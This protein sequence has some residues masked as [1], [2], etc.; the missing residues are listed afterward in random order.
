MD[1][2][3]GS[4]ITGIVNNGTF[5]FATITVAQAAVQTS[6]AGSGGAGAGNRGLIHLDAGIYSQATNGET[7]PLLMS[8]WIDIQGVGAKQTV[9]RG[10]QDTPVNSFLPLSDNGTCGVRTNNMV[11]VDFSSATNAS[12]DE[13]IDG[14]SFQGSDIQVYAEAGT[15]PIHGRVSNCIFDLLD[16]PGEGY[17][18]PQFGVLMVHR[19]QAS[20]GDPTDPVGGKGEP[21][22]GGGSAGV[23]HDVKLNVFNNTFVQSWDPT[24]LPGE[25]EPE[26]SAL[27]ESVA[28][29]DVNDPG[30]GTA[31][32][33]PTPS[34]RGVGNPN[35]QNNLIRAFDATPPSALLGIDNADVTCAVGTR[36]GATNG[37]DPL[38]VG[39]TGAAPVTP[40]MFYSSNVIGST[41]VPAQDALGTPLNPNGRTTGVDPAFAGE[42]IT[43]QIGGL[44]PNT[45]GRDW[46]L[47]S[48]SAYID[49]GSQPN[50]NGTFSAANGTVHT[51]LACGPQ[52]S[53]DS[54]GEYWG[55]QRVA[56]N[57][58][59]VAGSPAIIDIGYDEVGVLIDLGTAN[60]S[61]VHGP[62]PVAQF[63]PFTGQPYRVLMYP[64]T[65]G[66]TADFHGV[67][68]IN[69]PLAAF[70]AGFTAYSHFPG[71]LTTP[72]LFPGTFAAPFNQQWLDPT[73]GLGL[74]TYVGFEPL[75]LIAYTSVYDGSAH[76]FN[77]AA[78]PS[79][80][81]ITGAPAYFAEQAVYL[82][83][84]GPNAG[85]LLLSN[86]QGLHD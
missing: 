61:I 55:N 12:Y 49:Q 28:I 58:L 64:N 70:G 41:P 60:D 69:T 25:T 20:G 46:R 16:N 74:F 57:P 31:S 32:A 44:L 50:A 45:H 81:L 80:R 18:G 38:S 4:D 71:T 37:F 77:F 79:A 23:Y 13:M 34:L 47:S 6:L 35:I 82:P 26:F 54:D 24:P 42:T 83:A 27:D 39:G 67:L 29:C 9:L 76:S 11:L 52:S 73:G 63:G 56:A 48:S 3:N 21:G 51:D 85:A 8:D 7:Y 84:G 10:T 53:F 65:G 62:T 14:V 72:A 33:D 17:N 68:A 19:Y 5:P 43:S 30:C 36:L 22:G 75:N 2:I 66:A 40:G 78:P 1:P 59:L 86:L 15:S